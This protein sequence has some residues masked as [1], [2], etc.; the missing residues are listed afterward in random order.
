MPSPTA[1]GSSGPPR[2]Q[3][4]AAFAAIYLIWGSTYLAI[5]WA[6]ET[7]PPLAMASARFVVA[8]SLMYAWSR[9]SG[10]AKPRLDQWRGAA[11]SGCLLL[12]GGNGAVVVAEQWV[13]SGMA[14]LIVATVPLW[15]VLLDAAWWTKRKPEG[16]TMVGVLVGFGG[17][18]L[19]AGS[20]G[21]GG[22]GPEE[23]WG[24]GLILL[25][26]VAWAV[27]SLVSRYQVDPPPARMLVAMQMLAGSGALALAATVAGEWPEVDLA[28][29]STRS[30]WALVYLIVA[31][32]WIGYAAYVWLLTV[33]PP[34]QA[35]TY[36]FVNPVVALF[37]GWSLAD[38]P[39]TFRSLLG[40]AIILASVV[41]ITTTAGSRSEAGS[42]SR[43]GS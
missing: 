34:S 24:A 16:T 38:E 29:V 37:L 20:P 21:V 22:G 1:V 36:A 42:P 5:R 7:M 27:G 15:M 35:G 18:A 41:W 25:G 26:S 39:L 12:A 31:G 33:V 4:V 13:P 14:A 40:A 10:I 2:I 6:V 19:L 28:A 11:L 17:V 9:A 32:A 23:M 8:G 30:W 43:A 3:L